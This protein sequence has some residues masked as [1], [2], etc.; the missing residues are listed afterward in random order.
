MGNE[1]KVT[2][3][4]PPALAGFARKV[5]YLMGER[6]NT[7]HTGTSR[8]EIKTFLINLSIYQ[9]TII[10]FNWNVQKNQKRLSLSY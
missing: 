9:L 4:N 1:I 3:I 8:T 6:G 2:K 10:S 5:L 7:G